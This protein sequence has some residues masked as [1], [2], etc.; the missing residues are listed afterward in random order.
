MDNSHKYDKIKNHP[1]HVSQRHP[2]LSR[3][4]YAARFSPFAALTGYDDIVKEVARSTNE[5]YELDDD[6]KLRLSNRLSVVFDHLDEEPEVSITYFEPDRKKAGGEYVTVTGTVKRFDE[7][8]RVII[9]TDGKKIPSEELFDV[10]GKII[11][12]YLPDDF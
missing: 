10:K 8:D 3:A 6:A 2:Q 9:M 11:D 4:S 12:E 7:L 1:H 5:K